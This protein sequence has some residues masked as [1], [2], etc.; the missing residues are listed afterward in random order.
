M[1][2]IYL[3]TLKSLRIR[4]LDPDLDFCAFSYSLQR[5]LGKLFSGANLSTT[6]DSFETEHRCNEYCRFFKLNPF[7]DSAA[8][9]V[10]YLRT[11][12]GKEKE[13]G[14]SPTAK[15]LYGTKA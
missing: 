9:E 7:N 14:P 1:Q 3:A 13:V 5:D 4:E 10:E 11:R 2:A 8:D 15:Y 12:R 6:Y